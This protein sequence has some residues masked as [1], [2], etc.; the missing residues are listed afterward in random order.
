MNALTSLVVAAQEPQ[1]C[2]ER[3]DR[4]GGREARPRERG[5]RLGEHGTNIERSRILSAVASSAEPA[6][7]WGREERRAGRAAGRGPPTTKTP[8]TTSSTRSSGSEPCMRATQRALDRCCERLCGS[9]A[10]VCSTR[11]F[12]AQACRT[13]PRCRRPSPPRSPS[14]HPAPCRLGLGLPP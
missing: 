4:G 14:S 2:R 3:R 1:E 10:F 12:S 9:S 6:S 7:W 13:R 8:G 5:R 11:S